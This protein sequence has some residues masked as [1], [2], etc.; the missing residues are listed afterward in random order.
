MSDR[1]EMKRMV[2]VV[3]SLQA[4]GCTVAGLAKAHQVTARTI[5]R[6]FKRLRMG[7]VRISYSQ[8]AGKWTY[9]LKA[10]K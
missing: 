3:A 9:S 8:A 5:E 1:A 6:D 2:D 7:G 10:S 4:G